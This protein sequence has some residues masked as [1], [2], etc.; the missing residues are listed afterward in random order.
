MGQAD[1]LSRRADWV[2]EVEI[3]NKNQVM[4]KKKEWLEIR[5]I[6]KRQLLIEGEEKEIIVKLK[7]SEAKNDETVKA[8]EG[9]KK[10][11]VKVLRNDE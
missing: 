4:L 2:K 6:E 7:K 11:G 9:M 3:Y 10:A 8:V 5:A 1:S